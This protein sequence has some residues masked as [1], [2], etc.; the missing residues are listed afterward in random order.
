MPGSAF[1]ADSNERSKCETMHDAERLRKA[2][3]KLVQKVL[4]TSLEAFYGT[5]I[6]GIQK[7]KV[8]FIF[9]STINNLRFFYAEQM[10]CRL[11]N[12]IFK[13]IDG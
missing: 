12:Q 1:S 3:L 2:F 9:Y 11:S 8:F 5:L 7:L 13:K 10:Q 4:S 6:Q